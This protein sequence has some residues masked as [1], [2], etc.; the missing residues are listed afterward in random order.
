MTA[1]YNFRTQNKIGKEGEKFLDKFFAPRYEIAFATPEE[2]A[3]EIDRW[4]TNRKNNHRFSVEYKTDA[5]AGKSGKAFVELEGDHEHQRQGW[6]KM[7][8]AEYLIFYIPRPQTIYIVRFGDLRKRLPKWEA[9]YPR[10]PI[11][12]EAG[13]GYTTI[14]IAVPLHEFERCAVLVI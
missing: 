1:P 10:I 4:F 2:Q 6:A 14:G 3:K 12:N 5:R 11:P 8:E 7:S 9:N 13:G